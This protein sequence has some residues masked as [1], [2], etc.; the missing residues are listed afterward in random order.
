MMVSHRLSPPRGGSCS[1]RGTCAGVMPRATASLAPTPNLVNAEKTRRC[2]PLYAAAMEFN[3]A[4]LFE[5]AADVFP[6]RECLVAEGA[7]RTYTEMEQRAN[8]LAHA[9][10]AKGV[11]PGD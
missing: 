3:L 4:D 1:P 7:R 9:L 10:Q 6:D 8:R 11:R 5:H 2:C